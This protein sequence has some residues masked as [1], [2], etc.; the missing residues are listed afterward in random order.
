MSEHAR[1][2][3]ERIVLDL[4]IGWP[5][6]S[7]DL[8]VAP[9]SS[10]ITPTLD[11][12]AAEIW[13]AAAKIADNQA[14][15]YIKDHRTLGLPAVCRAADAVRDIAAALR[16]HSN[17]TESPSRTSRDGETC[18]GCHEVVRGGACCCKPA[19]SPSVD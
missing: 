15:A 17:P 13:E 10:Q 18:Q 8:L 6:D 9:M 5:R 4:F 16:A 19:E 1:K 2:V 3:A 7:V 11:A 14:L 12:Y